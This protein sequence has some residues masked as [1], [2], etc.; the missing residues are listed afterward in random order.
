M[1]KTI[2]QVTVIV[3]TYRDAHQW[4][5]EHHKDRIQEYEEDLR[6]IELSEQD[7]ITLGITSGATVLVSNEIGSVPVTAKLSLGCPQGFGY[8]PMTPHCQMLTQYDPE[9]A[10]L[11][12]YKRLEVKIEPYDE[13][14]Y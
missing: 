4:V 12:N 13:E 11:P 6:R 8:M 3:A 7:L 9:K 10:R 14:D 5:I 1:T 2:N